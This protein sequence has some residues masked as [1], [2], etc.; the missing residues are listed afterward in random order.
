MKRKIILFWGLFLF[1]ICFLHGQ[2]AGGDGT[3]NSPWQIVTPEHLDTVRNYV[4]T[5]NSDKYFILMNDIDLDTPPY[6]AGEGWVPLAP[7]AN[8]FSGNFIGDG[9]SIL[10]LYINRPINWYMS[11]FGVIGT[12]GVVTGLDLQYASV[13]GY[14]LAAGLV[15]D[16]KGLITNCSV[17]GVITGQTGVGAIAGDNFGGT[18]INCQ[19]RGTIN[20]LGN[21]GGG[22]VGRNRLNATITGSYST[23]T[24]N[25]TGNNS[26]GGLVGWNDNII[27]NSYATGNVN[28]VLYSG[29][30]VGRNYRGMI[31][32]CYATGDVISVE[33]WIGG[34]AGGNGSFDPAVIT[35][36]Y[37]T[38][39][40]QGNAAVGGLVG[41]NR[42][43]GVISN[44]YALGSAWGSNSA[45]G[46]YGVG[47]LL[48]DLYIGGLVEYSYSVGPVSG[49][50]PLGGL[51]GSNRGGNIIAS[52]WNVT[53]SNQ[54]TSSGGFGASTLEMIQQS[55]FLNW[56][57]IE[58]WQII[59]GIT[60]PYLRLNPQDPPPTP[61]GTP[62]IS[63]APDSF[64]LILYFGDVE[65]GTLLILNTGDA[66]LNFAL[67]VDDI[68]DRE[69]K[70]G[71]SERQEWISFNYHNGMIGPES[72]ME[73]TVL[74]DTNELE[75]GETYL[76]DI[77]IVN[78]ATDAIYIP[79]SLEVL[80]L[81]FPAP[82]N[83]QI[84][85]QTALFTWE[86]PPVRGRS[87]REQD[88]RFIINGYNVYLDGMLID[89][90][91][92]SFFQYSGLNVNQSYVAGV[93]AVYDPGVSAIAT[94]E[95]VYEG[96]DVDIPFSTL[97]TELTGNFPNPFNPETTI[98]F[99][100]Q[101]RD[102]VRISIFDIKGRLVTILE[103]SY[104]ES[105]SHRLVWNG[106]KENGAS[107]AS[108]IYF[109]RMETS[110]FNYTV[111]MLLLK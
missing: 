11:L 47:G 43:Y 10:N 2:F 29:G 17:S 102:W 67:Y 87:I 88:N 56:D 30:L 89:E 78:N 74:F 49:G 94:I 53:T 80:E 15:G 16:N 61:V 1:S 34:L 45:T 91:E 35:E 32:N 58:I 59:E 60:Y 13:T 8:P 39:N 101:E 64:D 98:I 12:T 111:K 26:Y 105:G 93:Q 95:F 9:Y 84:N 104:L 82:V 66:V 3:A 57:F 72:S 36:C 37:A 106:L 51:I 52:Y 96:V 77:I 44:S 55:I 71:K 65:E 81:E 70:E 14:S 21:N 79:V 86:A 28:G 62:V 50:Y 90:T 31:S 83:L 109:L 24:V 7:A 23:C 33:S 38:G 100:L 20:A 25:G 46:I 69:S 63:Y 5:A 97:R 40:V 68:P 6:N 54:A 75:A 110:G 27:T 99:S 85:P 48:G 18:I 108:G 107:V 19:S 41:E 22:L 73:I 42:N 92:E 76:A 103:E 4:G